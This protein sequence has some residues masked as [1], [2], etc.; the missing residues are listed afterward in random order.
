LRRLVT[1]FRTELALLKADVE[2]N[3]TTI[4]LLEGHAASNAATLFAGKPGNAFADVPLGDSS[5]KCV[6]DL[7]KKGLDAHGNLTASVWKSEPSTRYEFAIITAWMLDQFRTAS[8][9]RPS[10]LLTPAVA[11]S[12]DTLVTEFRPELDAL[13]TQ[14]EQL[15]GVK[16][17]DLQKAI[18]EWQAS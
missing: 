14:V 11:A 9:N 7:L 10:D 15:L 13:H 8:R 18:R 17:A 12:L 6:T 4:A 5:Y 1:E 2:V 16:P 3:V